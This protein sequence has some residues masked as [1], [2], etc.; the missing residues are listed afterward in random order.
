MQPLYY[1]YEYLQEQPASG[2][3][4][5]DPFGIERPWTLAVGLV[6]VLYYLCLLN[7]V[8]FIQL[9]F[10]QVPML[11]GGIITV[12]GLTCMALIAFSNNKF[13]L[14]FWAACIMWLGAN[15]SQVLGNG[16]I[17]IIAQGVNLMLFFTCQQ[18]MAYYLCQNSGSRKRLLLVMSIIVLALMGIAGEATGTG[19]VKRLSGTEGSGF[20]ANANGVAYVCS[21]LAVALVFWSQRA[22]KIGRPFLWVMAAALTI[23]TIQTLSRTGMLLLLVG[24]AMLL[25][26]ILAARGTRIGGL[27]FLLI[28]VLGA[29]QLAY[30]VADSFLLIQ[31][32]FAG[33]YSNTASR[34]GLYD[35]RT[36]SDLISTTPFG[37]GSDDAIMTS[38]G[39]TAH[40]TF[41]HIHMAFG[42]IT[43]WPLLIW[44]AI[45]AIR[46]FRMARASDYPVDKRIMIVTFYGMILAEYL[47]NNM[48]F[49]EIS[50]LYG[51]AI[52]D[53]YTAP[54]SR[55]AIAER[56]EQTAA[57][58][59]EM[60][61][62]TYGGPP[63]YA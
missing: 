36:L 21:F 18:I 33:E 24:G 22:V 53:F 14:T 17:P 20:L 47:T 10:Y 26:S 52:V 13:P 16:D 28:A 5:D 12:S 59:G 37:R 32:R 19:R 58:P 49:L 29:S 8:F 55:R 2:V 56:A 46:V 30:M 60:A 45:L 9:G 15:L 50:A 63:A 6:E 3:S 35:L 40:N 7:S 43:A 57:H 54:Y 27:V 48:A 31:E 42:A 11:S 34:L 41:V 1:E 44:Q 4:S 38:T 23:I 51:T 25:L 62:P 39:I 61:L